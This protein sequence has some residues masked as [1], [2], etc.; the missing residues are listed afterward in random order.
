MNILIIHTEEG[1]N[2]ALRIKSLLGEKGIIAESFILAVSKKGPGSFDKQFL[3]CFTPVSNKTEGFGHPLIPA[4]MLIASRLTASYFDFLAGY[5]SAL[6]L[7]FPVFGE[8]AIADIS[9]DYSD[10]FIPLENEEELVTFFEAEK[11]VFEY[12]ES[13]KGVKKAKDTL[14]DM[15][16]P[17]SAE[18]LSDCAAQSGIREIAL[19]LAAGFSPDTVNKKGIPLLHVAARNG[20]RETLRFLLYCGAQLDLLSQDRGSTALI[21]SVM[22]QHH[23]IVK[24]LIKAGAE[25]NTKNKTGQTALV[26]AVG[27]HNEKVVE[28][29]LKAGADPDIC[30]SMGESARKYAAL[31]RKSHI[32]E[33][34][35]TYA[36]KKDN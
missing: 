8:E 36:S 24:E 19:F 31:F 30:D 26:I 20:N 13:E 6:G 17:I 12:T 2:T 34:F 11:E 27:S 18:S 16:I 1:K 22:G 5:S 23:E 29:L 25:L 10:C 28:A 9:T 21:D 7:A 15:H 33:L 35:E 14:L 4:H 3:S 32:M